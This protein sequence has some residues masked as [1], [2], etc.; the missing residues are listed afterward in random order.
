LV[1]LPAILL[2]RELPTTWLPAFFVLV[3]V[4]QFRSLHHCHVLI[5]YHAHLIVPW[6]HCRT[7][8]FGKVLIPGMSSVDLDI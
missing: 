8:E 1:L 6:K 3:D 5:S 7:W 2:R 4:W